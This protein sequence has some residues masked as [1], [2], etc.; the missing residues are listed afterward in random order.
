MFRTSGQILEAAAVPL[1]LLVLGTGSFACMSMLIAAGVRTSERFLG[2]G[3]LITMPLFFAS[4]ALYPVAIM[5][6]WLRVLSHANP[7][8]YEVAALRGLL[9]DYGGV[10]TD[11]P[12]L[13]E[14]VRR[15]RAAGIAT[16]LART[17]S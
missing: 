13:A 7:L 4:S 3:Q 5:P 11:G 15:A 8:T 6:T 2:I 10:L 16:A 14:A 9:M 1:V 12:E 17:M